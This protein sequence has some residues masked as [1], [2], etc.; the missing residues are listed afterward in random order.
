MLNLQDSQKYCELFWFNTYLT[1]LM[2]I[3]SW[4]IPSWTWKCNFY[5]GSTWRLNMQKIILAKSHDQAKGGTQKIK[6]NKQTIWIWK[7]WTN[8]NTEKSTCCCFSAPHMIKFLIKICKK[9]FGLLFGIIWRKR[10]WYITVQVRFCFLE[11]TVK[12]PFTVVVL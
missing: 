1:I 12:T 3:K 10:I 6:W 2:F 5:Y 11:F 7:F 9:Y 8:G 4:F